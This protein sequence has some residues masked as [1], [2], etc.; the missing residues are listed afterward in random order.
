MDAGCL[1]FAGFAFSIALDSLRLA[2]AGNKAGD[3]PAPAFQVNQEIR[4]GHGRV[5]NGY[6][7]GEVGENHSRRTKAFD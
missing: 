7:A 1:Q 3:L 5:R 4:E 6:R 2:T